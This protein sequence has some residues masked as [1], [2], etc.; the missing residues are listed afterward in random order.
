MVFT[1]HIE[2]VFHAKNLGVLRIDLFNY[3]VVYI[4]LDFGSE[5][6]PNRLSQV[7]SLIGRSVFANYHNSGI[8]AFGC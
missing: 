1:S 5:I 2:E 4:S 3:L 8:R 7:E 6:S